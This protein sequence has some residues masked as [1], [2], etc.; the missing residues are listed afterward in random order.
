MLYFNVVNIFDDIHQLF[1]TNFCTRWNRQFLE[2]SLRNA[3]DLANSILIFRGDNRNGNPF[4]ACATRPSASMRI[5]FHI[6]RQTVIDNVGNIAHV[7]TPCRYVCC[8]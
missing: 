1:F 6:I 7:N 3:L 5:D 8:N 2:F 4:F